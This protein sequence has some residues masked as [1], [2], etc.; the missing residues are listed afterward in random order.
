MST[1]IIRKYSLAAGLIAASFGSGMA[2]AAVTNVEGSAGGGLVP[3][4]LMHPQG[5]LVSYTHVDVNDYKIQSVAVAGTIANMVELS[6]AKQMVNAPAVGT[7]LGL[8]NRID[9]TTFGAKVKLVDMGKDNAIPQIAIGVQ[10]KSTSGAIIDA[11]KTAGA[12]SGK[13]GTDWYAAATKFVT[14]GGNKVVLDGTLRAT[15]AN[16]MGVLGFGGGTINN[17]NNYKLMP[18][19][20]AGVFVADNVVLGA[21][22]RAKP[23]NIGKAAFGIQE[24]GAWDIFMAYFVSKNMAI[25][26]AY[27]NL[28]QVGPSRTAVPAMAAKQDGLYVQL[29]ANF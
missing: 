1:R 27:A 23:N 11:L 14:I 7:A 5:P 16:Q 29:Q 26:A 12:I 10:S 3:W 20:S 13:S 9:M 8:N 21:E 28:G 6:L 22:Y 2:Q 19:V 15:K 18:E 17:N 24:N 25:T 4:A